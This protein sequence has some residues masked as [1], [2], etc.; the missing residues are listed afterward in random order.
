MSHMPPPIEISGVIPRLGVK[1]DHFPQR[2]ETGIGALM[3]WA[4]RLWFITYT[5][6]KA[7]TGGGTGLFWIDEEFVLEKHAASVVGT[8]ANRL[9]HY[10]SDQLIIGPHLI[11]TEGRVRTIEDLVD[12]RLTA[13]CRHLSN[14]EHKVYMLGMEGEFYEVDVRTLEVTHLFDLCEELDSRGY[15]HFK[16]AVTRHGRVVVVNN[17]YFHDD[18]AR[19]ESEGR[20]AEWDG[21]E[22]SVLERTQFNTL[23]TGNGIGEAI[24]AVGQDRAS[25]LLKVYLPSTGWLR[26]RLPR[27]THTQDHAFTTEWPRIRE[28]ESERLLMDAGGM[29]YELPAMT[30]ADAVWGVR[31]I[32]SHL[33]IVG[34]FCSWNGLLVMAG[35][36]TT[37][38][39]DTNPVAGQPQAGLWFGKSDD[40]WS[41]G[42]VQ[43][44]GGPWWHTDVRAG[45]ASDPYLMTGF[46]NPFLHLTN[47]GD[48]PLDVHVEVD[49]LGIGEWHRFETIPLRARTYV[50]HAFPGG[51][52]AH[53]IRLVPTADASVT[54]QLTYT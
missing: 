11:D 47:D 2:S 12:V 33:R 31:P 14:P 54:G 4:G 9:I 23:A 34:D 16:D 13:T 51:F 28:V 3:P 45:E 37:P 22:W 10:E 7:A 46:R 53:W 40:L 1:A 50:A 38:I 43:G 20:L 52:N 29:F 24:Y 27:A 21:N 39:H 30:Y 5:A 42:P 32:A 19:G 17:S 36:Q 49:F 18:F 25:T 41:W 8:Y 26:Y 15:P 6:H 35:D 44:W 48:V